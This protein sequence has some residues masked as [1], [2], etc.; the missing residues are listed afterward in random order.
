LAEV[1]LARKVKVEGQGRF[2]ERGIRVTLTNKQIGYELRCADPIAFDAAYCRDLGYAAVRFLSEGGSSAMVSVQDGR[3]VPIRFEEMRT[4]AG[5]T[6]V[7]NVD[8]GSDGYRKAR[9]YMRWLE[10]AGFCDAAGV[11]R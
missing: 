8:I 6:R 9:E 11:G 10:T 4:A 2:S 3:M 5:R 1:D 7:R